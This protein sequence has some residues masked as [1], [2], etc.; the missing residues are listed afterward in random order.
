MNK[1]DP[2]LHAKIFARAAKAR[3]DFSVFIEL[4]WTFD[5]MKHQKQWLKALEKVVSGETLELLLIAPRGAGKSAVFI[6]F[7]AWMIGN[8][9]TKRYG[10]I[11]YTD[12]IA[13][14]RSKAIKYIIQF[15]PVYHLIFPDIKP[16]FSNWSRES[17]TVIRPSIA[18][19]HPTLI[20]V[21]STG[22]VVSSRLDGLVYD[23]PHDEKNSKTPAKRRAVVE[24]YDGTIA[25]CLMEGAWQVCIATRYA[26]DDLPGKFIVRGFEVIHQRAITRSYTKGGDMTK[27]GQERSYAP[28]LKSLKTLRIERERNPL[29]FE[30][31][32]QGVTTGERISIIK[33]IHIYQAD[34]LPELDSLLIAAG[35][36]TNYKD[37]EANDYTVVYLGG[38]DKKGNVWILHREK[39]RWD[40]DELANL[41]INLHEEWKYVTNWIE[42]AGKGTPAVT[43]VKKRAP[44]V[45]CELQTPTRGGKRSR[46]LAI[47]PHINN[48]QVK[49][50]ANAEWLQDAEYH[51]TRYGYT[52]HD[53]DVDALFMLLTNIFQTIH[54]SMYG[55]GRPRCTVSFGGKKR[56]GY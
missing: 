24:T 6:L 16:D 17:F 29:V 54:P 46:A 39:D 41:L 50:P 42:D 52:T 55:E 14:R 21:G 33:K 26:D 1:I 43:M 12:K 23:D 32:M 30:L 49:F 37:G 25:P 31:Q 8:N 34:E 19:P 15:S 13:W 38:I 47:G 56:R 11:S 28:K 9:P 53:D 35:T 4:I 44:Y 48:G 10:L 36:D 45:P 3:D 20:A 40:V 7:L 18:N 5:L 22:S 51:L 27:A 2:V